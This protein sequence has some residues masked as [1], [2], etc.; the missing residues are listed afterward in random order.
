MTFARVLFWII[1]ADF[2]MV[3]Y[4]RRVF[5]PIKKFDDIGDATRFAILSVKNPDHPI[6]IIRRGA[7]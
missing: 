5:E 6:N 3:G 1:D 4:R 2:V 7:S